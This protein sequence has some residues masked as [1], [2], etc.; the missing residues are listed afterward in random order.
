MRFGS[1]AYSG[2]SLCCEIASTT[3]LKRQKCKLGSWVRLGGGGVVDAK[4]PFQ[5][6]LQTA[7]R[8]NEYVTLYLNW[9]YNIV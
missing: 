3:Q 7:V 8:T 5:L 4:L 2:G 9:F 1:L 6:S